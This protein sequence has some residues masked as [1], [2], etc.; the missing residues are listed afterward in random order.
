LG[1]IK[2]LIKQTVL[3]LFFQVAKKFVKKRSKKWKKIRKWS[4]FG[5]S[6]WP[7]VKERKSSKKYQI[8][9]F[10]CQCVAMD[11]YG[12][13]IFKICTFTSGL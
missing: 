3:Q 11:E 10:G 9:I 8:S 13:L 12:S 5:G 7:E 2:K 4:D 1:Y 6:P